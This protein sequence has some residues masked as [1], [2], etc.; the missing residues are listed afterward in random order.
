LA[1]ARLARARALDPDRAHRMDGLKDLADAY[2]AV[3]NLLGRPPWPM[4]RRSIAKAC[5]IR[6]PA[7]PSRCQSHREVLRLDL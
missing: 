7:S 6:R 2:R 4:R 1:A 5:S 3:A